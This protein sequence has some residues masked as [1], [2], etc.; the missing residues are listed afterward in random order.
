MKLKYF[1]LIAEQSFKTG[2]GGERLFYYIGNFWPK[3]YIIP[4]PETEKRL[5]TKYLW[6]VRIS[7]STLI[8]GQP[9]LLL[10]KSEIV[11]APYWF[12][13]YTVSVLFL[14]WLVIWIAFRK[15]LRTLKRATV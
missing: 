14:I 2:P 12:V 15:D 10:V 4:D 3:P 7:I 5:F 11:K 9:F 8:V 1:S 13:I 6:I